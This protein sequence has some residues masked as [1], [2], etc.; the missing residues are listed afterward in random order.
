MSVPLPVNG[1]S[2]LGLVIS[3]EKVRGKNTVLVSNH[4]QRNAALKAAGVEMG[5]RFVSVAGET[6]VDAKGARAM[7][8]SLVTGP[9]NKWPIAVVF[10]R[11][12]LTEGD[13]LPP[14][15]VQN[16]QRSV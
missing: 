12:P 5:M 1:S 14:I 16:P 6:V 11:L 2:V 13:E 8:H 3:D 7:L 9:S 15:N 4:A 10:Q